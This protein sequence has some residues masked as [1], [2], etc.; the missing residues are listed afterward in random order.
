MAMNKAE[1]A[2]LQA[3][4]D[5]LALVRAMHFPDYPVPQPMSREEIEA[6]KVDG[7][8]Q[9]GSPQKVARGYFYNVYFGSFGEPTKVTYG[10]SSGSTHSS[11]G[12]TTTT[13]NMGRMYA[14][15]ADAWRA[16]RHEATTK[17]AK[18]LAD[19]DA[20]IEGATE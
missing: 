16:A 11:A 15:E 13:Q 8:M 3:A 9:Y 18:I 12:D 7:G 4:R 5:A 17:V 1:K 2:E 10:C 20:A 6:A 19:I 14:T